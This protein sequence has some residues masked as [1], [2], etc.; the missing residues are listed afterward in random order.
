M[1]EY[2]DRENYCENICY[3]S[4]EYC[5]RVSCHIWKAPAADVVPVSELL[6]L[7]DALYENDQITMRGLARLNMLIAK[8]GGYDH[9]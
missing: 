9:G 2:I 8:Y 4:N 3:C 1:D 7:R 5:D 6:A